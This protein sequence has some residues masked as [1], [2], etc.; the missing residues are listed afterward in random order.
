MIKF[1][2]ID[3]E[4]VG[5]RKESYRED[6][7]NPQV[8][9]GSLQ[10]DQNRRDFTINAMAVSLNTQDYGTL[11]DPFNGLNDLENKL[12]RTPLDPVITYSDD[13]LRML[14]AI[15]FA[16][17]LDFSIEQ[18]SLNAIFQERERLKIITKERIVEELNKIMATAV[19]SKGFLLLD[20]VGLLEDI[21][22]ELTDLK[23]IEEVEGQT[24]DGPFMPT[25]LWEPRWFI[26]SSNV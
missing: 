18:T 3:L 20:Q 26:N 5:A 22:P 8:E 23:G 9:E 10:D 4:F 15:R 13:P 25:N 17:Q 2:G 11:I 21:L 12:I 7:R 19:P 6:S 16:T 1:E 24:Q 14:R